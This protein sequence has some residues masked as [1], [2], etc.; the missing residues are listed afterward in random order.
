M[1]ALDEPLL[2]GKGGEVAQHVKV[3]FD[4][5]IIRCELR[6]NNTRVKRVG[7]DERE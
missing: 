7:R 5:Y 2:G 3:R 6:V 1:E 4:R